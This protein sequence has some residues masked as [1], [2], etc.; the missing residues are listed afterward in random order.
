MGMLDIHQDVR[1]ISSLI[2]EREPNSHL[3]ISSPYLNLTENY[4]KLLLDSKGTCEILTASP[5]ANGFYFA[6]DISKYIPAA[7]SAMEQ[8]FQSE[9]KF[10]GREVGT[11]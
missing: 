6:K 2:S 7:Y 3:L 9:I 5:L 1:A 11:W 10:K 4:K 8:N